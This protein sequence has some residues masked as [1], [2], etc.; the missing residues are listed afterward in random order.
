MSYV[1]Y[2]YDNNIHDNILLYRTLP[3]RTTG[4]EIFLSPDSY[5][6]KKR[7]QWEKCVAFCSDGARALTGRRSGVVSKVKEAAPDMNWVH[8]F[9]Y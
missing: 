3:T 6:R 2:A 8:C 1:R 4:E 9:I 7:I 5:I